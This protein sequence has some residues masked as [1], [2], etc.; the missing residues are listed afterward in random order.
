MGGDSN[1]GRIKRNHTRILSKDVDECEHLDVLI[2]HDRPR[3][4]LF[5]IVFSPRHSL[6]IT[7]SSLIC[8][9]IIFLPRK[10]VRHHHLPLEEERVGGPKGWQFDEWDERGG[11]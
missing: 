11:M 8:E 3:R 4:F 9:G 5:A 1:R 6:R 2:S 7:C 10:D